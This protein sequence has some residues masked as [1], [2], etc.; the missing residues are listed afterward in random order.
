MVDVDT[1]RTLHPAK[2]AEYQLTQYEEIDM[3]K[4]EPPSGSIRLLMPAK[5]PGFGFHDKKWSMLR[6]L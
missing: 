5:V 1:H 3:S 4:E 6:A 2:Y